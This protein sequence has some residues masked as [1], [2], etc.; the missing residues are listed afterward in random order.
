ME[1]PKTFEV[2]VALFY[3]GGRSK[4]EAVKKA[5]REYPDLHVEYLQRLKA[6][7]RD[8]LTVLLEAHDDGLRRQFHAS[9]ALQKEFRNADVY[10]AYERARREGRIGRLTGRR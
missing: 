2:A 3:A 8:S 9:Q 10:V 4:G 7:V 1:K 6:G 5:V